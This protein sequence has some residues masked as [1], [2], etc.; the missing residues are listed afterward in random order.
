MRPLALSLLSFWGAILLA[1]CATS[2]PDVPPIAQSVKPATPEIVGPKGQLGGAQARVVIPRE[3]RGSDADQLINTTV[4]LMESL[5]GRPLPAGNKVTLLVDGP[6]TYGAM[7]KAI[8]G[9]KDHINFETLVFADNGRC[10]NRPWFYTI[11]TG[12]CPCSFLAFIHVAFSLVIMK[13]EVVINEE[14]V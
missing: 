10:S 12:P 3:Q 1:G 8:E 11:F 9:P 4:S 14:R 5:N 2:L 13:S 7:F 6:A